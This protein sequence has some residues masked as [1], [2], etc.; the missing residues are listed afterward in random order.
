MPYNDTPLPTETPANSQNLIRQNFSAIAS[1]WNADHVPLSS[2]TNVGFSN[3]QTFIVQ[4]VGP[5]SAGNQLVEYVKTVTYPNLVGPFTELF[6]QR[7][8]LAPQVQMTMEPSNPITT[9]PGQ[10]FLPGGLGIK[11]GTT[12][13]N[14]TGT[15][16]YTTQGLTDFPNDTLVVILTAQNNGRQYNWSPIDRTGFT[17]TASSVGGANVSWLAIGY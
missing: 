9:A 1:S 7:D 6:F 14:G 13:I 4:S 8:G 12:N 3:K 2:G 15:L 11:W 16:D 17:I 10:S 5:G